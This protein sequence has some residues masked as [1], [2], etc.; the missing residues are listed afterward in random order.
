MLSNLWYGRF[1]SLQFLKM[2]M[3]KWSSEFSWFFCHTKEMDTENGVRYDR[4][5][6]LS[7]RCCHLRPHCIYFIGWKSAM[8][9]WA[10]FFIFSAEKFTAS[11]AKASEK[12]MAYLGSVGKRSKFGLSSTCPCIILTMLL[13]V[14]SFDSFEI[15]F[16]IV[17]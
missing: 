17:E 13:S 9:I 12:A 7:T 3:N 5:A 8:L 10:L 15:A 6:N 2:L 14:V 4:S 16:T 1:S 11:L